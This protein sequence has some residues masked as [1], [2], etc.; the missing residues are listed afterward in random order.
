MRPVCAL[1]AAKPIFTGFMRTVQ[2]RYSDECRF[3]AKLG[4][5]IRDSPPT[6]P[7]CSLR[8]SS[9]A[10]RAKPTAC[11][12]TSLA[13]VFF[14]MVAVPSWPW[15]SLHML[16]AIMTAKVVVVL[17]FCL[18]VGIFCVAPPLGQVFS[19]D[20][21]VRHGADHK[22]RGRETTVNIFS[23]SSRTNLA[24]HCAGKHC[25]A[26]RLRRLCR[27]RRL[28]QRHLQQFCPDKGWGMGSVVGAIQAPWADATS[29]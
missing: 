3:D 22:C 18:L 7:P 16:Q 24:G 6:A 26:G 28:V 29:R 4:A 15:K 11:W 13:Y 23:N 1:L 10:R 27:R 17:G 12:Y 2:A 14:L 5:L 21:S 9:I 19:A 25:V 8:F 20:S